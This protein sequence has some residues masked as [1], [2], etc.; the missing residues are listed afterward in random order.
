MRVWSQ[1]QFITTSSSPS[2]FHPSHSLV[3]W[4]S[5]NGCSVH[6][7]L[8]D[9]GPMEPPLGPSNFLH[10]WM[11]E[12][13]GWARPELAYRRNVPVASTEFPPPAR[14]DDW[15]SWQN[16]LHHVE[17]SMVHP[18]GCPM[19]SR[20]GQYRSHLQHQLLWFPQR[21]RILKNLR[22]FWRSFCQCRFRVVE[23]SVKTVSQCFK[24]QEISRLC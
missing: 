21:T 17:W 5:T 1:W 15:C 19:H 18:H 4:N 9:H 6:C 10:I 16:R 20:P 11:L 23:N 14:L 22:Y 12:E 24:Q 7:L 2:S 8:V 13:K 3:V